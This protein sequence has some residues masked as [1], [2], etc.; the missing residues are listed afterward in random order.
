MA[1]ERDP[2][3]VGRRLHEVRT[4]RGLSA[5]QLAD[6]VAGRAVSK[7]VITNVE[8]GRKRD[9]TVT[10]LVLLADALQVSP[11]FLIVDP[12]HPWEKVDIPGIE[13]TNVEYARRADIFSVLQPSNGV[14]WGGA[15]SAETALAQGEDAVAE[16]QEVRRVLDADAPPS[17]PWE[18]RIL[19]NPNEALQQPVSEL[20]RAVDSLLRYK[21]R[22]DRREQ[23]HRQLDSAVVRE[24]TE[25]LQKE[26]E[27]ARR[28]YPH[29][30]FSRM[31]VGW[32]HRPKDEADDGTPAD[33]A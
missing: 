30:N 3:L 33:P 5:S 22:D 31:I 32:K 1:T 25:V 21:E 10:E 7:T 2:S 27:Q 18:A 8:S 20:F 9:L 13:M 28:D 24:R 17:S 26:L 4:A 12:R 11:L 16:L 15:G 6:R 14:F 23:Q 19:S 29:L